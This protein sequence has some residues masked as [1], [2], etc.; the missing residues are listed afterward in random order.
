MRWRCPNQCRRR[1]RRRDDAVGCLV[2]SW[3]LRLLMCCLLPEHTQEARL[4]AHAN[5]SR[6]D[7][8]V[9]D[10]TISDSETY[11]PTADKFINTDP[12]VYLSWDPR[13][14]YTLGALTIYPLV[15]SAV[16]NMGVDVKCVT[17][18]MIKRHSKNSVNFIS[19]FSSNYSQVNTVVIMIERIYIYKNT[20]TPFQVISNNYV[21]TMGLM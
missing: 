19:N 18:V 15:W 2:R 4:T 8:I 20:H 1:C 5:T 10:V 17:D 9:T 14:P 7:S 11:N 16:F 3:M 6:G 12:W 21:V 13:Y